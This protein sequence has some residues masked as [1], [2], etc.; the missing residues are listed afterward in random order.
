MNNCLSAATGT[1]LRV[2]GCLIDIS[3]IIINSVWE[4]VQSEGRQ[5]CFEDRLIAV[6]APRA[7]LRVA[8]HS[9]N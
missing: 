5:I 1:L 7:F 2:D 9:R 6:R 4:F 8:G 3:S